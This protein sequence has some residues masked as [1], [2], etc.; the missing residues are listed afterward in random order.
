[1]GVE[2]IGDKVP[3]PHY[4]IRLYPA[5]DMVRKILLISG[6][7]APG[8]DN[9][10]HS[11]VKVEDKRQGSVPNILE[12]TPFDFSRP[13]GQPWIFP[14]Q[15]LNTCHFINTFKSFTLLAALSRLL[16]T[17][18]DIVHLL[19]KALIRCWRQ[20]VTD[21]MRFKIALFLKALPHVGRR[22]SL[23]CLFS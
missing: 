8:G 19:V 10:S 22:F 12:L 14:F 15:C 21:L 11:N 4:R 2:I 13:H 5:L 17:L 20:P 1:M 23:Q 16:V 3:L 6:W 9:F 7:P 18:V